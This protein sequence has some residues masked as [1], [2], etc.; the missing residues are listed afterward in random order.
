[1]RRDPLV[2]S[3]LQALAEAAPDTDQ[4]DDRWIEYDIAFHHGLAGEARFEREIGGS[5]HAIEF[6]IIHRRKVDLSAGFHVHVASGAS[7]ASAA[8]M[9][10]LNA[11][12][13]RDVENRFR[14]PMLLVGK[15]SG[16]ELHRAAYI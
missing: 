14:F 4:A 7:A 12:V 5:L 8:G 6:V 10:Q 13:Q 1:M 15:F 11:K 2:Y 16:L 9:L 3:D